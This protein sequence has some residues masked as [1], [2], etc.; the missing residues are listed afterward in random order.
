LGATG[1]H[2]FRNSH[3]IQVASLIRV[4]A[5]SGQPGTVILAGVCLRVVWKRLRLKAFQHV[6][7]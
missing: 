3:G 7:A 2:D 1:V 5:I 6:Y 4:R